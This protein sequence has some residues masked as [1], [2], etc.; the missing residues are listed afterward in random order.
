MLDLLLR[1]ALDHGLVTEPG[2]APK[3]VR[4]A[5]VCDAGGGFLDVLEIGDTGQKKNPGRLFERCPD[6]RQDQMV[7]KGGP[8]SHFLAD[9]AEIVA[10]YG[11]KGDEQKIRVKHDSFV[12]LFSQSG[13]AMPQ[14]GLIARML[15]DGQ[16]LEAIR[17]RLKA[18]GAR[19]ADRVTFRFGGEYPLESDAWHD[20]W[21]SFMKTLAGELGKLRM[22]CFVSGDLVTP[23][24]INPKIEGLSDVGG[25]PVGTV[26]IGFDKESFC[27]YGLSQAANAAVSEEAAS[28]YRAALNHLIRNNG[29]KLAGTKVVHWF[30][31]EVL[32]ENDP[33]EWLRGGEDD[34]ES[35]ALRQ[36]RTFFKSIPN[37][38]R[39]SSFEGNYYYAITLSGS[40]GRVMVRDWME[41]QFEELTRCVLKWFNDLEIVH[42]DG[43]GPALAPKFLAVVGA[44]ARD[45]DDVPANIAAVLW[46]IAVRGELIPQFV[47]SQALRR[48]QIGFMKDEP[49]NHARMGLLKAYHIRKNRVEGGDSMTQDIKPSLNEEHPHPAYHCGR[50]MAL[51]A[52]LQRAALG[53]VG[54]GVVQRYYAAASST[55]ALV[56]GRL[57]RTS[58][59]HLNKL[60]APLA[61]WYENMIAAVWARI[62]DVVPRTLTLEEQSL[63][64]LGYYQQMASK[65]ER[66]STEDKPQEDAHE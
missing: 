57:T 19:P 64:A 25:Q 38:K 10:L 3:R 34:R 5:I 56:L 2:F 44:T 30:K 66:K 20:W 42:R 33:L 15:E 14:L 55:P 54:A 1:Y 49:P 39:P 43:Q 32:P 13:K 27:S 24:R 17:S 35:S 18:Q 58:Q 47:M 61:R 52:R 26:L 6:L 29:F 28:T 23:A 31:E 53:D 40:G 9:A 45:L 48:A 16:K 11:A 59:F 62:R 41:G 51:M 50:L 60:E 46:R 63:F 12:S 22:R 4:W 7:S 37:G 8:K 65:P 36:G 21:R